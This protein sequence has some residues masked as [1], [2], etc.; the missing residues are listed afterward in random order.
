[1]P[2]PSPALRRASIAACIWSILFAAPHIWWAAG[3]PFGF[4][5]GRAAHAF[6]FSSAWRT[7]YDLL[8]VA[9]SAL[10]A[11]I[12]IR[13]GRERPSQQSVLTALAWAAAGILGL[14]GIAGLIADGFADPIWSP[15]FTIGGILFAWLAWRARREARAA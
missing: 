4:P 5:G 12:A 11:F 9:L 13:L 2:R 10:A 3:I 15:A 6:M 8:V 7:A 14:R 1:M